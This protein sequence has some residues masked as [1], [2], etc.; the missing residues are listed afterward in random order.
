MDLSFQEK[1]KQFEN[2]THGCR[3]INQTRWLIFFYTPC[4]RWEKRKKRNKIMSF[5]VVTNVVDSRQPERRPTGTPDAR[6]NYTFLLD[7]L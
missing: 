7:A 3:D 2:P 4:R 5:I 1:K 6:G